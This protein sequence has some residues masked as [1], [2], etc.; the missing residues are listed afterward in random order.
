MT[1]IHLSFVSSPGQCLIVEL[2]L[3]QS[4]DVISEE[5]TNIPNFYVLNMYYIYIF[6]FQT[7]V[8][9]GLN[10]EELFYICMYYFFLLNR[11]SWGAEQGRI[12]G[13]G[14]QGA[15]RLVQAT[16]G[17]SCKDPSSKQVSAT[18]FFSFRP[19]CSNVGNYICT[20]NG[21]ASKWDFTDNWLLISIYLF[22]FWEGLVLH[23]TQ[24]FIHM[25]QVWR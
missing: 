19:Y 8:V 10:K 3:L 7:D 14:P 17:A 23:I 12:E 11:C 6:Y 21:W 15:W 22:V 1:H 13:E 9:E 20:G 24:P 16:W 4:Y 5:G 25:G 18:K 2:A